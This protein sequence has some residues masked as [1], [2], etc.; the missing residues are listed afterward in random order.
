MYTHSQLP[1][2][3]AFLLVSQC[4]L[5]RPGLICGHLSSLSVPSTLW[6]NTYGVLGMS[7]HTSGFCKTVYGDLT[8]QALTSPFLLLLALACHLLRPESYSVSMCDL[9]FSSILFS[10]SPV[11]KNSSTG[12]FHSLC[13]PS[14][15]QR[16]FDFKV[17]ASALPK[18]EDHAGEVSI[19]FLSI[20]FSSTFLSLFPLFVTSKFTT[21]KSLTLL[22]WL[23]FLSVHISKDHS[24][25][26]DFPA[27][28]SPTFQANQMSSSIS[29]SGTL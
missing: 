17:C 25:S 15:F 9:L 24:W 2:P 26:V 6:E 16:C 10:I 23:H 20:N 8:M 3:L 7:L 1:G 12:P 21:F 18:G 22:F 27:V 14:P 19:L 13:V 29:I 28:A 11:C 4:F 5:H